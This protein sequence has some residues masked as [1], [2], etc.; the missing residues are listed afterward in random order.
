MSKLAAIL[1]VLAF[2][3]STTIAQARVGRTSDDDCAADST[4]PDCQSAPGGP[5]KTAPPAK[6]PPAA[7]K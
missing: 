3:S 2:I 5:A 4:D 7:P 1:A 6:P